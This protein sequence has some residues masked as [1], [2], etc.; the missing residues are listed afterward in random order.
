MAFAPTDVRLPWARHGLR[1]GRA[2]AA[3]VGPPSSIGAYGE[4]R[5][6]HVS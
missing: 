3:A 2:Q 6:P 1:V 4:L 5:E